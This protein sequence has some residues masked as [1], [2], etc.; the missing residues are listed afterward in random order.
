MWKGCIKIF[1]LGLKG[2][3][4][5]EGAGDAQGEGFGKAALADG[6]K[7][8]APPLPPA[9]GPKRRSQSTGAAPTGS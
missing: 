9:P 4:V 1:V 2:Q 6:G 8:A 7:S 5:V 3:H